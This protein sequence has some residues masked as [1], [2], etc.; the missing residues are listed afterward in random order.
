MIAMIAIK[1]TYCIHIKK[2]VCRP[3]IILPLSHTKVGIVL[4]VTLFGAMATRDV[5]RCKLFFT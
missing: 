5:L 2:Y 3:T 4:G 1:L